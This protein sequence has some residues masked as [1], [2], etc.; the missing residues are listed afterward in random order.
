MSDFTT[1]PPIGSATERL[2][3]PPAMTSL[4]RVLSA[5]SHKEPDRVPLF[6]LVSMHGARELG[7]SIKDYFSKPENVVEGQLRMR[8]K[9]GHDCL[10]GF[11]YTPIEIEA[12]GGE[13][14]YHQAGPPNSGRP[15]IEST[16]QIDRLVAPKVAET[17]CL[18]KVLTALEQL[19]AKAGDEVPI[20]G[21]VVS[22]F[23]LPVMQMGFDRYLELIYEEP[24][25]FERLMEVNENFCVEWANAQLAAG[26]TAICYFDPVSS[27]TIVPKELYLKTGC[28][29]ARRT[30]AR[31]KGPAAIHLASGR[32][33]PILGNLAQSGAAAV[34]VS[35]LED[36]AQLK[37]G[38][39]GKIAL[40]G[41]LNGITMRRWSPTDAENAVK[42]AIAKAGPGG[43]FI[44][45]DNHGEIPWEVP[46][47][48]LLAIAKAVRKWGNYP[49][50]WVKEAENSGKPGA[51]PW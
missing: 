29:I 42:S 5:L 43:G 49:L 18:A 27:P 14:I 17:A 34:G 44:L 48:V 46:E 37:A 7:L 16:R 22:P 38:A 33:L 35:A 26:A 31:F 41:N 4:Q 25:S 30:L 11:F 45:S 21:V 6:L 3:I 24:E 2:T 39:S 1:C 36:L 10:Y 19:K 13:V 23:S 28:P 20:I 51:L 32:G 15:F 8:D 12:W 47:P 40:L 50:D 9:Y